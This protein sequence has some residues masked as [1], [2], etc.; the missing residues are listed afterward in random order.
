[1]TTMSLPGRPIGQAS[2]RRQ[3]LAQVLRTVASPGPWSRARIAAETGLTR[4]TVSSLVAD[5]INRRLVREGSVERGG[6]GRPGQ[7]LMLDA[8]HVAFLGVEINVDY[9]ACHVLDLTGATTARRV[10]GLDVRRLDPAKTMQK[11]GKL[12]NS[13]VGAL[14]DRTVQSLHLAI[15]GMIETTAGRVAY[16][17]NLRWRDVDA[18]GLLA[19]EVDLPAI[20]I[21]ADNEANLAALAEFTAGSAAGSRHLVLVTGEVGVGGGVITGGSLLRGARGYSGEFGHMALAD[22]SF[23]CGCGRRGCWEAAI[24]LD[25]ILARICDPGDILR[26]AS[27]DLPSR[28]AEITARAD[29]GDLRTRDGLRAVG[30]I[31]GRGAASLVNAFNPEV[32]M[33]GGTFAALEAHLAEPIAR[34]LAEHVIAPEAGGCRVEFSTLGFNAAGIGGAHAGI[35][36][37]MEDPTSV[38]PVRVPMRSG[39]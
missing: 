9:L 11:V 13:L 31:L 4:A 35:R 38:A 22:P 15:P 10:V 5:L 14:G 3:H 26:D 24:G 1:M 30:E 25:A 29:G 18:A 19:A 7:L 36:L 16:A 28:L 6:L 2:L 32:L 20:R 34:A 12:V 8:D 17:P 39:R 21:A 33:F 37:V 27:Q 23:R